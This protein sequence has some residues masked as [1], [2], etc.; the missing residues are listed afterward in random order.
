MIIVVI[1]FFVPFSCKHYKSQVFSKKVGRVNFTMRL[2]PGNLAQQL[3]PK[4]VWILS[5]LHLCHNP[6]CINMIMLTLKV[7]HPYINH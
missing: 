2:I 1:S 4:I 3:R 7:L 6:F 5:T